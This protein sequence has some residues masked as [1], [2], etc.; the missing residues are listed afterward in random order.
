M[1]QRRDVVFATQEKKADK[2]PKP[3]WWLCL[4]A[5]EVITDKISSAV[6]KM[7]YKTITPREQLRT[8][9]NLCTNLCMASQTQSTHNGEVS[10]CATR[11]ELMICSEKVN[12]WSAYQQASENDKNMVFESV[13]EALRVFVSDVDHICTN[14]S[15]VP[16][17]PQTPYKI[18][19][20][21]LDIFM[22][23]VAM[24]RDKSSACSGMSLVK[25]IARERNK[26]VA[27]AA[28]PHRG[29]ALPRTT[30]AVESDFSI[31]EGTMSN[32]IRALSNYA[33][34]GQMQAKQF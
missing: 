29:T 16:L 33:V 26:L 23:G 9:C 1:S 32:N 34:Q 15:S 14:A 10:F 28:S 5:V 21:S 22:E 27:A 8:Q 11:L 24:R 18:V 25:S 2:M 7:Q 30:H 3:T 31:L 20:G 17:L 6:T 4:Y 19:Y 12:A 13:I